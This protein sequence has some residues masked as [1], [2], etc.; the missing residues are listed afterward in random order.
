MKRFD[1]VVVGAGMIGTT[2]A[3]MLNQL[4]RGKLS[5]AVIESIQ[6]DRR[7]SL[8]LDSRFIALSYGTLG[9]L[10]RFQLWQPISSMI[11]P[12]NYVHVS[13]RSHPGS[14][15]ICVNELNLDVLGCVIN[16]TD[17]ARTYDNLLKKAYNVQLFCPESVV[18]IKQTRKHSNISLL[19]GEKLQS[20]LLVGADGTASI[21]CK[22]IG[23]EF[24]EHD[25]KQVAVVANIITS[26]SHEGRAFERF[27]QSGS[28][29]LLPIKGNCFSLVW[30]LSSRLAEKVMSYDDENFLNELQK[31]FSW[32]LGKLLKVGKRISYPLLLRYRKRNIAHR[33][34][35]VGNAAQTLHPIV[36][37]GFNLGIRDIASLAEEVVASAPSGIGSYDTL[38]AFKN[39]RNL[40]RDRTI[41]LTSGLVHLFSNDCLLKKIGRNLG[42]FAMDNM[43]ILKVPLL[44]HTLGIIRH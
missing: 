9:I 37:Q 33:F 11:T 10:K 5:L 24:K 22:Q 36:G 2:L 16:L 19:S 26:K 12:I 29:A 32:Y 34:V 21:C 39:R 35:V 38:V 6:S 3:L 8:D 20:K 13:D 17:V 1:V 18:E 4:S 27:T 44:R 15:N 43:F 7:F 42:L 14:M 28:V 25:F 40:D 31:E 23:L 41:R 30:C